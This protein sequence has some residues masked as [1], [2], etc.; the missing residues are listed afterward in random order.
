ML[1][2]GGGNLRDR[3]APEHPLGCSNDAISYVRGPADEMA[4]PARRRALCRHERLCKPNAA[5]GAERYDRS[6]GRSSGHQADRRVGRIHRPARAD[7]I[8]RGPRPRRRLSASLLFQRRRHR[9]AGR[10]VVRHRPASVRSEGEGSGSRREASPGQ[11]VEAKSALASTIADRKAAESQL[12][13]EAASLP[14]RRSAGRRQHD[15][16]GRI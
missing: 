4:C 12:E 8:R 6:R 15:C 1:C 10:F 11:E 3:D 7:R 9:Q 16:Q 5:T 13:L 14:P 2:P